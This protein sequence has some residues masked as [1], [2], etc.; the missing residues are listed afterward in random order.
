MWGV[1]VDED[2]CQIALFVY[3]CCTIHFGLCGL[4][5]IDVKMKVYDMSIIN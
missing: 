4:K 2:I 1:H 3:L 5:K